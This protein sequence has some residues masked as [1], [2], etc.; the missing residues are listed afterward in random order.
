MRREKPATPETRVTFCLA[1]GPSA[2]YSLALVGM[3]KVEET[4]LPGGTISFVIPAM[5]GQIFD[6][7]GVRY[8]DND[9]SRF[10]AVQFKHKGEIMRRL[11]LKDIEALPLGKDGCR[12]LSAPPAG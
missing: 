2:D 3:K 8:I 7:F 10:E 5:E 12:E 4:F 9:P 6:V 1:G 11:S